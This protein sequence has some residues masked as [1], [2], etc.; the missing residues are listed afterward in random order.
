MRGLEKRID[1]VLSALKAAPMRKR[2]RNFIFGDKPAGC[3]N[4][5]HIGVIFFARQG[6]F[7][8]PG[9]KRLRAMK[10]KPHQLSILPVGVKEYFVFRQ[11]SFPELRI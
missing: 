2:S 3:W 5:R 11:K 7:F 6:Q 1:A 4:S 10:M 8:Q 9:K